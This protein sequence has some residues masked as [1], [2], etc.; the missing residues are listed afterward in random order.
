[1]LQLSVLAR[2]GVYVVLPA[3]LLL[4]SGLCIYTF[5]KEDGAADVQAKWNADVRARNDAVQKLKD[6]YHEQEN[7]HAADSQKVADVLQQA[8]DAHAKE[9][10]AVRTELARSLQR[11]ESRAAIYQREAAGGAAQCAG[12]ASHTAE[13]DR[14]LVEG[15]DVVKE[16]IA[17]IGLRDDQLVQVGNQLLAD[18]K[19]LNGPN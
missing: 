19:L 18:R 9:L 14:S 7:Q 16:L 13:L 12:L 3:V 10:D 11:S 4:G 6:A 17:T 15:Q 1:M 8:S 5:G 2:I